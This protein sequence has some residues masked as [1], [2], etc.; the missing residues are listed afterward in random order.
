MNCFYCRWRTERWSIILIAGGC[1]AYVDNTRQWHWYS[2]LYCRWDGRP[3]ELRSVS[4]PSSENELYEN[5]T[6]LLYFISN[7]R[8]FMDVVSKFVE[9]KSQD[10]AGY[11]SNDTYEVVC[12][13]DT[14]ATT[15]SRS[16]LFA[17]RGQLHYESPI[18]S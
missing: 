5:D 13:Y 18:Q 9:A 17:R 12:T 15:A 2:T 4:K 7:M 16:W 3:H 1:N 10:T 14:D 11:R 8:E 6:D